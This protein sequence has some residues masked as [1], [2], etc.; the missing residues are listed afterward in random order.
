[1]YISSTSCT[2]LKGPRARQGGDTIGMAGSVINFAQFSEYREGNCEFPG[3][4]NCNEISHMQICRSAEPCYDLCRNIFTYCTALHCTALHCTAL[5]C[6]ALHCTA[7]HCTV[8]YCN[9]AW[10]IAWP[11]RSMTPIFFILIHVFVACCMGTFQASTT[12][13]FNNL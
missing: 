7:L 10:L 11:T 13:I 4:L 3:Q 8:L 9:V 5:H 1:M 2:F 6:T 12:E